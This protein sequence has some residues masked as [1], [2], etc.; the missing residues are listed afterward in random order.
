VKRLQAGGC[1]LDRDALHK[2]FS[3]KAELP[4]STWLGVQ[5]LAED[6]FLIDG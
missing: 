3:Q 1:G 6:G 5:S 2:Y 4:A